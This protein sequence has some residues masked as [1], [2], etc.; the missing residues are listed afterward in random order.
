MP[1]RT[2]LA[3]LPSGMTD[4]QI[5]ARKRAAEAQA[6]QAEGLVVVRTADPAIPA[7]L[8]LAAEAWGIS[9][10]GRRGT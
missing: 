3:R 1:V 2:S 4:E 10:F 6:W 8:R 7:H 9:R 5:E